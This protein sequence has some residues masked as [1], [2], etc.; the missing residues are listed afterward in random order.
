MVEPESEEPLSCVVNAVQLGV[1]DL[2]Y[3]QCG[4]HAPTSVC[5]Y[6]H[7][8]SAVHDRH[9]CW[10]R[11]NSKL[12]STLK[13]ALQKQMDSQNQAWCLLYQ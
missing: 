7:S 1:P 4:C 9:V 8:R 10:S 11:A 13:P 3:C 12:C 5:K 6:V 2:M